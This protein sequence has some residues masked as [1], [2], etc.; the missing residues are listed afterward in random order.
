MSLVNSVKAFL[1][2]GGAQIANMAISIIRVKIIAV[3]MGPYGI[4]MLGLFN[5]VRDSVINIAHLG[6]PNSGVKTLSQEDRE[7]QKLAEIQGSIF[8]SLF[9]QGALAFF[10]IWIFEDQLNKYI[11]DGKLA[12]WELLLV[13]AS[14]WLALIGF[15]ILTILQAFRRISEI[16]KYAVYGSLIGSSLGVF[17]IFIYEEKAIALFLLSLALG[18]IIVGGLL[19]LKSKDIFIIKLTSFRVILRHWINMSR[20][21]ISLMLSGV[22]L[23]LTMLVMRSYIQRAIGIDAVG[24]FEAAWVLS[25]T[26]IALFLNTMA[27]DYFPKLSSIIGDNF[28]V[29]ETVNNHIQIVLFLAGPLIILFIGFAPWLVSLLYSKDFFDS[30]IILQWFM[31]GNYF[32]LICLSFSYIILS[33]G[34]GRLYLA[35]EVIFSIS[36]ALIFWILFIDL[37]VLA[38]GPAYVA[39]Y[40][41]QICFLYYFIGKLVRFKLYCQTI[42]IMIYNLAVLIVVMCAAQYSQIMGA[43]LAL[44]FFL[45]G[46]VIG[47]RFLIKDLG[48]ENTFKKLLSRL[49]NKT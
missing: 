27:A 13:G 28:K 44:L 30:H 25:I 16:A 38:I 33:K 42:I 6:I 26:L 36:F 8:I 34:Y 37:S 15:A 3:L 5:S 1:V 21:G 24:Q 7:S 29:H 47:Y 48:S 12:S 45:I 11:F 31:I 35:L 10:V 23:T 14:V 43:Y 9:L 46:L 39:A 18:Q 2:I 40:L 20:L 22:A 4:G 17:F 49:I 41:I 32:K 19:I